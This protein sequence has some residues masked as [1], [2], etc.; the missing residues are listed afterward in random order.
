MNNP[1]YERLPGRGWSW[2]GPA[3]LWLANDHLL[4]VQSRTFMESY[5]RFFLRDIQGIL[6]ERT[7]TAQLWSAIWAAGVAFFGIMALIV[8]GTAAVVL[9]V[10]AAPFAIALIVNLALGPSCAT[11]IRTAVQMERVTAVSRVRAARQFLARVEP[12]IRAA[13]ADLPTEKIAAEPPADAPPAEAP[14]V[15]ES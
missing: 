3:H 8:G 2:T 7:Q 14:P 11:Y 15:M 5:R 13:Q 10:I 6:V 4:H 1:N 9:L 12:L